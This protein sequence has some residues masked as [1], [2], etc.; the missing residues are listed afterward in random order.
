MP[1]L[2]LPCA[3]D[4]SSEACRPPTVT[5]TASRLP[6]CAP[7]GRANRIRAATAIGSRFTE[8][9][10]VIIARTQQAPGQSES[11]LPFCNPA[12]LPS[13]NVEMYLIVVFG[14]IDYDP[15]A[16]QIVQIR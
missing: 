6:V 4:N 5:P 9:A 8:E 3:A 15:A 10:R 14:E 7:A 16:D 13:C 12:I 2:T 11:S 1:K